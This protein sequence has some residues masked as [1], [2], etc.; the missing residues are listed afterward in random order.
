MLRCH[1][2]CYRDVWWSKNTVYVETL[3]PRRFVSPA[4]DS[5]LLYVHN[6]SMSDNGTFKCDFY[7]ITGG[8]SVQT[9]VQLLVIGMRRH[10][11][12]KTY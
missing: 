10:R 4:N 12:H 6:V 11:L 8:K 9:Q 3:T 7:H 5:S 1:G 2:A